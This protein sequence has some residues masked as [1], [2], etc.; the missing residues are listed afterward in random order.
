MCAFMVALLRLM[1]L[2]IAL[3]GLVLGRTRRGD[4]GGVHHGAGLEHQA[5]LGQACVDGAEHLWREFVLLQQVPEPQDGG[6]VGHADCAFEADEAAV[7]RP[8]VQLLL[9]GRI[10]QVPPQLQAVD[11]QHGLDGERRSTAQRLVGASSVWLDQR[12]QLRPRHN[13][14]HLIEEDFLAGLLG[15][16]VQAKRHLIHASN[17]PTPS[18]H[19]TVGMTRGFAD[20]P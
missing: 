15:Q 6:L 7:Q 2:G 8:L 12:D 5:M 17:R 4:D 18:S 14:V 3:A 16:R 11:A 13:L 20:C 1:H 9:H 19:A 10:A